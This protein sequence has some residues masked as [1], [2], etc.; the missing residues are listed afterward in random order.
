MALVLIDMGLYSLNLPT[1]CLQIAYRFWGR[2]ET[3]SKP[4]SSDRWP[5]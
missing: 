4:G 3:A 1:D 5:G 2:H